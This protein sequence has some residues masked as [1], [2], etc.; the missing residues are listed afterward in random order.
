MQQKSRLKNLADRIWWTAVAFMLGTLPAVFVVQTAVVVIHYGFIR[1]Q[2]VAAKITDF[3]PN[4]ENCSEWRLKLDDGH[5]FQVCDT[6]R[7]EHEIGQRVSVEMYESPLA[8]ELRYAADLPETK[9]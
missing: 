7:E 5:I 3:Y 2:T 6:G 1:P 4:S 9:Q 8:Y